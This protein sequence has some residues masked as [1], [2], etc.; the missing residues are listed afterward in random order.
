M[1]LEERIRDMIEP[2][3]NDM[4]FDLV[5]VRVSGSQRVTL[6]IMADRLDET[7]IS[8]EDCADVSRAVSALLDVEDPIDDAYSLEVSSPGIDRPLT[9]LKDFARFAG[10]EAK[11]ELDRLTDGRRRF[12][13]IL[14]GIEG[15]AVRIE[16]DTGV[17]EIPFEIIRDAKLV[18]TDAL[19]EASRAAAGPDGT[20]EG[21]AV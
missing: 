2:S 8:V 21:S 16:T 20:T 9:R 5:R 14:H 4:G 17:F 10:H 11:I 12:R 3:L 15:E 7:P 18:L 19:L 1:A 13:G 6:Q